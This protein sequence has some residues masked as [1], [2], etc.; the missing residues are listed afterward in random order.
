MIKYDEW[1]DLGGDGPTLAE[2][3]R[4]VD[5]H[6]RIPDDVRA[7]MFAEIKSKIESLGE[8]ET[9]QYSKHG[10]TF[11]LQRSNASGEF[12]SSSMLRISDSQIE[13]A[14]D[15]LE[16][17]L[18][19]AGALPHTVI[20]IKGQ[21]FVC[22]V[23]NSAFSTAESRRRYVR[24]GIGGF[25]AT[26]FVDP[27]DF[28]GAPPAPDSSVDHDAAETLTKLQAWLAGPKILQ[29]PHQ[30]SMLQAM[31][32]LRLVPAVARID[33]KGRTV[34]SVI[35]SVPDL[36]ELH[37]LLIDHDW[38]AVLG[39][40]PDTTGEWS[41]PF[42][43]CCFELHISG[44]RLCVFTSNMEH[45]VAAFITIKINGAWLYDLHWLEYH[46]DACRD[47]FNY[48]LRGGVSLKPVRDFV[49]KVIRASSIMLEAQVA[50]AETERAPYKRNKLS[51]DFSMPLPDYS[52][53]RL[54]LTRRQRASKL[55]DDYEHQPG[56]RKRLHFRRSHWRHYSDHKTKIPWM[57]VGD[58][59]LGFVEKEYRL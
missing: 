56:R 43:L 44:C 15:P 17:A 25:A 57:L 28:K 53:H 12:E 40:H 36:G 55:S 10:L 54:C 6:P 2:I 24:D 45:N 38:A 13:A 9:C 4:L 46:A 37:A 59:D 29:R 35:E 49:F 33:A 58:P 26:S 23:R 14:T 21:E 42:D 7:S 30:S 32:E 16:S 34:N 22:K 1:V 48:P 19:K 11:S 18:L 3:K 51:S 5:T 31:K 27:N 8:G 20:N 52:F 39:D 41:L 50:V 47:L